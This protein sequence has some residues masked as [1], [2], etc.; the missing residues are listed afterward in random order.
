MLMRNI[1]QIAPEALNLYSFRDV[2][3]LYNSPELKAHYTKLLKAIDSVVISIKIPYDDVIE[4]LR[5]LG[6]RHKD[7]GVIKDHYNVMG[8]A[9]IASL[10]ESLADEFTLEV[11]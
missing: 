7:Y 4:T 10:D 11:K 9:L 1:F 8:R 2:T 5:K 6:R 3:D